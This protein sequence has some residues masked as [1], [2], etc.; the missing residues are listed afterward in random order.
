ML[1][2]CG[3]EVTSTE[4]P[5]LDATALN[6]TAVSQATADSLQTQQAAPST[7]MTLTSTWT[8]VPTLDRT[9]P[10]G[11]TP[12]PEKPCNQAAAG[13]PIDVTI[14]D[15]T[16]LAPGETFSKTWRLEN[17]GSC[18]WSQAYAVVFFSGNSMNA[19]QT[20]PLVGE[21]S[22]GQVI[23]ITVDME[24]PQTEGIYQ[25]NWM[26]SDPGGNLFGIGPNGDAPFWVR[27]EV[28]KKLTDTPTPTPTI[29]TTPVVY[30]SGE[31]DLV[32]E[33]QFDLDTG[34]L[35][36]ADAT[37]SDMIYQ[38]GGDPDHI[39]LTMNGT[40]WVVFGETK[41]TFGHCAEAVLSGN[42]ISF[43]D[44][45]VGTYLCYRTSDGLPGRL[46]IEGVADG[47]LS[48]SFLTWSIP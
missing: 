23:D 19:I 42:A 32:N 35:N 6:R 40:Q 24:A 28:V 31:G 3:G 20:Q 43:N 37:S 38:T 46:L 41:P 48:V 25:S 33:D 39:L 11:A 47:T 44:V 34:A 26:L 1:T 8:P 22:S 12:T 18:K 17:V 36:P 30:L 14:P 45:P 15:E 27:I 2:A 10:S 13:H 9:R 16:V 21:V 5:T 4:A 7:T 29:T